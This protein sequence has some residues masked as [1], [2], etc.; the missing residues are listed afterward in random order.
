[1][2]S[3]GSISTKWAKVLSFVWEKYF[4]IQKS[5][6]LI[7]FL[8]MFFKLYRLNNATVCETRMLKKVF[9]T[10]EKSVF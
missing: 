5:S 8:V 10:L 6:L 1:M 3:N 2:R 4:F 9:K 7:T